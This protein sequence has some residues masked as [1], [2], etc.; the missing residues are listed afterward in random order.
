MGHARSQ[1][2]EYDQKRKRHIPRV[3]RMRDGGC[4]RSS[5]AKRGE[6]LL[7]QGPIHHQ[8][9]DRACNVSLHR[10]SLVGAGGGCQKAAQLGAGTMAA[11][12]A[13]EDG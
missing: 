10:R 1:E 8:G 3:P 7:L 9:R 12:G 13:I 11:M 2:E 4:D 5:G 6:G